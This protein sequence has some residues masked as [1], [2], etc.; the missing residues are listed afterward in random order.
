MWK[1]K[2]TAN[3][4]YGLIIQL[5]QKGKDKDV[6]PEY[7]S[8]FEKILG[9]GK[10]EDSWK[11]YSPSSMLD[12]FTLAIYRKRVFLYKKTQMKDVGTTIDE[13]IRSIIS[14][15]D[16]WSRLFSSL[17]PKD[18][19]HRYIPF[20]FIDKIAFKPSDT[21]I[22]EPV[23]SFNYRVFNSDTGKLGVIRISR[24]IL[25]CCGLN[26]YLLQ[27]SINSCYENLLIENRDIISDDVFRFMDSIEKFSISSEENIYLQELSIKVAVF[28]S[29]IVT[30]LTF[31]DEAMLLKLSLITK[32]VFLIIYL[33]VVIFLMKFIARIP[34]TGRK[35]R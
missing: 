13:A 22:G 27:E 34:F 6:L 12:G 28:L 11:V 10:S 25:V 26:N 29:L 17:L 16:E 19:E 5:F 33:A 35:S 2:N 9:K 23:T 15:K 32:I 30:S 1:I 31:I 3:I 24:H 14:K 18:V 7:T 8:H 4:H 20:L 21:F